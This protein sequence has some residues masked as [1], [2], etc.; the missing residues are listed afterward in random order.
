MKERK[1]KKENPNIQRNKQRKRKIETVNEIKK[2]TK[3][4]KVRK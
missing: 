3:R 4:N 2:L 1:R